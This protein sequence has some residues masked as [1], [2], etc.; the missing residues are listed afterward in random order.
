[1]GANSRMAG[2][3]A[4]RW[5]NKG[6]GGTQSALGS[7]VIDAGGVHG[8]LARVTL[9]LTMTLRQAPASLTLSQPFIGPDAQKKLT[10]EGGVRAQGPTAG[11]GQSHAEEL[12]AAFV[13]LVVWLVWFFHQRKQL[14]LMSYLPKPK[15]LCTHLQSPLRDHVASPG[16]G[17]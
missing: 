4:Q 12:G 7:V 8:D 5:D 1:M 16:E 17:V 13:C 11:K 14:L 6:I 9:V 10:H 15:Q 3:Q 2:L